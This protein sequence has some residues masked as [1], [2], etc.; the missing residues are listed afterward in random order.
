MRIL[1]KPGSALLI[2]VLLTVLSKSMAIAGDYA[3]R[4]VVGFSTDGRY[5]SFEQF[6]V[7]DG[8]GFPYSE[9]FIIDTE[10]DSW[11]KGAPVK[12]LLEDENK[13][14]GEA[15]KQA[16]SEAESLLSQYGISDSGEHLASNPRAEISAD[17]HN[18][19]INA[20]Y[21]MTPPAE[22][23][24]R[25]SIKEKSL[26]SERCSAFTDEEIK[27]LT[28]IM[29]RNGQSSA[30]QD[31]EHLPESRGCP[32]GYSFA[33]IYRHVSGD[34]QTFVI[35]LHMEQIGFEGPDSR[36]LAITERLP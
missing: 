36:F 18:I 32:L 19:A 30:L 13:G 17:P 22:E 23:I 14:V 20:A 15:R 2:L 4:E 33:D 9:I 29:T 21:Q 12:I 28:L 35:L 25:F 16:R 31:D 24:V 34:T 1:R 11:V 8:S 26:N 6:G 3:S 10:S 5:F 7:Q 27:G